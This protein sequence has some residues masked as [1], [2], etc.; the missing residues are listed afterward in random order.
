MQR[1]PVIL[2]T[3]YLGAGKT[4]LLNHLLSSEPIAQQRVALIV[5]EFGTMG[6]DGALIEGD[7][8][9]MYEINKGSLFCICTKVDLL[10]ALTDIANTVKP[11]IVLVEATGIAEPADFLSLI[12]SPALAEHFSVQA[13]VGVVDARNF[14][15]VAPFVQA[16]RRQ[17]QAVDGLI[18]NKSD[19][20]PASEI[21]TLQTLL[22]EMNPTAQ[23]V[24]VDHAR[25]ELAWLAGLRHQPAI[26][27][28]PPAQKPPEEIYA[29]SFQSDQ[30]MHRAKFNAL[31]T[32]WGENLLRLKG[33]IDF[34]EGAVF[35]ELVGKDVSEKPA[36]A[37]KGPATSFTAIAWRRTKEELQSAF[38][39][40][41]LG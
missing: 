41:V 11:D 23:Q 10:N 34:G 3:G 40:T 6:V 27:K 5:N 39:Q 18:L 37:L 21:H 19:L 24:I 1:I 7:P 31:L 14:T 30:P 20:V 25:I 36:A 28:L 22:R 26:T 35:V 2:V 38:Q 33:N 15:Q 32:E 16:V 8:A 4:T 9:A 17:A 12:D 13:A 29:L